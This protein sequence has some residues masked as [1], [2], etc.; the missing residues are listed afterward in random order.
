MP[1]PPS[2]PVVGSSSH[3]WSQTSLAKPCGLHLSYLRA[4]ISM[5]SFVH[6]HP[7][8]KGPQQG[9]TCPVLVQTHRHCWWKAGV[10]HGSMVSPLS[11]LFHVAGLRLS[12]RKQI[13][14]NC[15]SVVWL[16]DSQLLWQ[17]TGN[18]S[19]H[20]LYSFREEKLPHS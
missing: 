5:A 3:C 10:P 20:D 9:Q 16:C 11:C 1:S 8:T 18:I 15:L 7:Y 4:E 19:L 17:V 2:S 12:S 13:L 14:F 6:H